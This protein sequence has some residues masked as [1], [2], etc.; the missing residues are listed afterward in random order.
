MVKKQWQSP[1][2]RLLKAGSAESSNKPGND[3]T[4]GG[5]TDS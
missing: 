3:K 2:V 4:G 5:K 1:K